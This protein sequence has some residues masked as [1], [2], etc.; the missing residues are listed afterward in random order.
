VRTAAISRQNNKRRTNVVAR[1]PRRRPD[2]FIMSAR[3]GPRA[4]VA[5]DVLD[6]VVQMRRRFSSWWPHQDRG[7]AQYSS[8]GGQR[9]VRRGS[10]PVRRQQLGPELRRHQSTVA[11]WCLIWGWSGPVDIFREWIRCPVCPKSVW[12]RRSTP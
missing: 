5:T 11:G 6:T 7:G 10:R 12:C 3:C 8:V 9:G 4:R 2:E 1:A